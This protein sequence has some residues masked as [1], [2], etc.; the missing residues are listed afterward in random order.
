ME[1]VKE[2]LLQI[3]VGI[4]FFLGWSIRLFVGW[5]QFSRRGVGGLQHFKYY[6]L[7]L[8]ILFMEGIFKTLGLAMM[9]LGTLGWIVKQCWI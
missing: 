8:F 6:L 9:V 7:G 1:M 4:F 3:P 5:R 2:F